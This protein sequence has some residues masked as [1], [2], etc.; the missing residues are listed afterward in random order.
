MK[1]SEIFE[2]TKVL[3]FEKNFEMIGFKMN[4]SE[5]G[6]FFGIERVNS[7]WKGRVTFVGDFCLRDSIMQ[8]H[9]YLHCFKT[10]K[11]FAKFLQTMKKIQHLNQR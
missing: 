2:E 8:P 11:G 3:K 7:S 4:P 9:F 6:G 1:V 10:K 5:N